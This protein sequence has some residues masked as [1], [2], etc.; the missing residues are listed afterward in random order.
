MSLPHKSRV[1]PPPEVRACPEPLPTYEAADH[2]RECFLSEYEEHRPHVVIVEWE[3]EFYV[4][5]GKE[6]F[7]GFTEYEDD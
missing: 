3:G 6:N 7:K 5:Y 1:L 2:E 4:V